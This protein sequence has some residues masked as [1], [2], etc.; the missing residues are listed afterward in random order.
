MENSPDPSRNEHT[1]KIEENSLDHLPI[2]RE[3]KI[4][5]GIIACILVVG[6]VVLF[7]II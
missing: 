5:L 7:L 3:N 2:S 4:W 6:F 1:P